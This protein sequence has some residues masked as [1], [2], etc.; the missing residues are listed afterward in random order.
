MYWVRWYTM[1]YSDEEGESVI[2]YPIT[3]ALALILLA[4][5][6]HI[7]GGLIESLSV[8]PARN[9][10]ASNSA[11]DYDRIERNWVQLICAFQLVSV[12][13]AAVAIVLY[14]L[15]FTDYLMPAQSIAVGMSLLFVL[16][17][18]SWLLQLSFLKRPARDYLFLGHWSFWFLCSGLT[19]WGAQAL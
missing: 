10:G 17:G 4:F 15:A 14:L 19:Y 5:F 8:R 12:D 18:I 6:A 3:A 1:F 7:T 16:W 11:S 13:L 9:G 2:N